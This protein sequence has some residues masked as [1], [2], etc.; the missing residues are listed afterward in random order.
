MAAEPVR[1]PARLHRTL[2]GLGV[3]EAVG[4]GDV[5]LSCAALRCTALRCKHAERKGPDALSHLSRKDVCLFASRCD[6]APGGMTKAARRGRRDPARPRAPA[7]LSGVSGP[8][9]Q[10]AKQTKER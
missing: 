10:I 4:G 9:L 1:H 8:A 7:G 3:M 6:N 5:V 2:S